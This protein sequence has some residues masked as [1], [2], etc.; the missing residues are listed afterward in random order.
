MKKIDTKALVEGAVFASLTAVLGI[1]V[2][3]IPLLSLIGMF[4]AVPIIIIGFRNGFRISFISALVA[5]I[6]VSLFTEPYSGIYLFLVFGISGIV[7]GNL[8]NKKIRPSINLLVS[9]LVLG[10][11]SAVGIIMSFW[12]IGQTPSHAI[13]QLIKTMYEV[14]ENVA[15]IYES[16]GMAKE[17]I[18]IVITKFTDSIEAVRLIIP[19]FF[20]T[21]GMFF[22]FVNFKLTKII[23]NRMKYTIEDIKS[24]SLWKLPDNFS[25]GLLFL[26]FLTLA[27]YYLKVPNIEIAIKNIIF[28][29][30]WVFIVLGLSVASFITNKYGL[31][32]YL[33][34]FILFFL[35]LALP[36]VLMI[37]GIFDT[38]FDIRKI[39][40]KYSGGI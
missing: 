36:N 20:L 7:M 25:I 33:K 5:G 27:S 30:Q 39:G 15:D 23:L 24:F 40:K 38:I 12:I 17:Q 19:A 8:M 35:F 14:T 9:G 29:L 31:N 10:I 21:N 11:C 22:S 32:K 3:Y 6:L 13:E 2:Y 37:A 1:M 4:W 34:A 26:M 28:L 16:M 18:D